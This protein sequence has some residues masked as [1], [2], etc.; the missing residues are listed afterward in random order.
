M[1]AK[2]SRQSLLRVPHYALA[3]GS[4]N[5]GVSPVLQ[6]PDSQLDIVHQR[7]LTAGYWV[8]K[9]NKPAA[10]QSHFDATLDRELLDVMRPRGCCPAW[11]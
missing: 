8:L 5:E 2:R 3:S 7:E 4:V 10:K 11:L 6:K 1:D 9:A